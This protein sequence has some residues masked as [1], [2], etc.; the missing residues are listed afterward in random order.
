[1]KRSSILVTV[2]G[3]GLLMGAAMFK[4]PQVTANPS[5]LYLA[6]QAKMALG[7]TTGGL[8]LISR[9]ARGREVEQ[10]AMPVPQ[11][12]PT[13]AM[14]ASKACSER[15]A[16]TVQQPTISAK[17]ESKK[18]GNNV[19]VVKNPG[20]SFRFV[21]AKMTVPSDP[22]GGHQDVPGMT[23]EQVARVTA[24]YQQHV[25]RWSEEQASRQ[26][27]V[28]KLDRVAATISESMKGRHGQMI[29]VV[30]PEAPALTAIPPQPPRANP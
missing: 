7:D 11:A 22:F 26:F 12:K 18:F 14:Q 19:V 4:A 17:A 23:R 2:V 13:Q 25:Q 28:A 16:T 24:E 10:Q 20:T 5:L 1:M 6:G 9:A 30:V 27:E 21:M 15:T 8:Q 3:S 29:R